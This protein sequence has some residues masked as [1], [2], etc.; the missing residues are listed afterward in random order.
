MT[1]PFVQ[2][3]DEA[4]IAR[5]VSELGAEISADYGERLPS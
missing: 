4:R 5:R 1:E 2:V 3:V